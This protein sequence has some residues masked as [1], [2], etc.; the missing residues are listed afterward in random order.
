MGSKSKVK[1]IKRGE[2]KVEPAKVF[3]SEISNFLAWIQLEKGLADNTVSSYENDLVQFAIYLDQA[4]VSSWQSVDLDN[5]SSWLRTLTNEEYAIS[6]LSRKLS[7]VR[8]L[9]K[10][11]LGE[12]ILQND[13]T[14]LLPNPKK[15]K[16]LPDF[17]TIDEMEKFLSAPNLNT[18]L[19]KRDRALFELMYGSGLR[20]SEICS[21]AM[22][23]VDCEEGLPEFLEKGEGKNC[24]CR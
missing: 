4:G 19:G 18:P 9:S 24:S 3:E 21:L 14:E 15:Q 16:H 22:T 11:L 7:A 10:F 23:A 8:M 20:V 5:V 12:G 13:F 6:S 1:Q 17:L 2:I